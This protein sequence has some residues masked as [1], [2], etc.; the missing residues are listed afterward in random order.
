VL[1]ATGAETVPAA[2]FPSD[3]PGELG[4]D[5]LDGEPEFLATDGGVIDTSTGADERFRLPVA[6]GVLVYARLRRDVLN[7]VP[8]ITVVEYAPDDIE[9]KQLRAIF[10]PDR[11]DSDRLGFAGTDD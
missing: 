7:R 11:L 1:F 4:G 5:H 3:A 10:H 2:I 9:A 8:Q 6:G